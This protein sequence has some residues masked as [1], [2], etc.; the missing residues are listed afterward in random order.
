MSSILKLADGTELPLASAPTQ[1]TA[2][3]DGQMR[4]GYIIRITADGLTAE[5]INAIVSDSAKTSTWDIVNDGVTAGS[6]SNYTVLAN[7]VTLDNNVLSFTL[8]KQTDLEIEVAA[9][10]GAIAEMS[11]LI[12]GGTK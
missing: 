4:T 1:T 7:G 2:Y 9:Q 3:A 10:A 11:M 12:A 6:Y 8:C 5:G